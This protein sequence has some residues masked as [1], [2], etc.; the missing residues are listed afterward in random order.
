MSV[1]YRFRNTAGYLW[2][3]AN[4]DPPYLHLAGDPV[5]FRGD[6]WHQKT[7]VPGLSC[8]VVCMIPC[9]AVLVELRLVTDTDTDRQTQAYG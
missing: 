9:L 7:K 1:L 8:G 3:V 6:L 5:E 4:F 2:K